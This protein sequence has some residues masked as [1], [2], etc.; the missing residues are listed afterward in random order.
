MAWNDEYYDK[1]GKPLDSN[2]GEQ[3]IF[4]KNGNQIGHT[5]GD[6]FYDMN[7]NRLSNSSDDVDYKPIKGKLFGWF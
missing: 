2:D 5:D 7:S 3:D 4:D 6:T 1:S